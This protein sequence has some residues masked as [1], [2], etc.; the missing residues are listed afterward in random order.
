MTI[1]KDWVKMRY[2]ELCFT[3]PKNDEK[4]TYIKILDND[5]RP[6]ATLVVCDKC[7]NFLRKIL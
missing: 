5:Y 7:L 6:R 2:C 4:F 1:T 3:E